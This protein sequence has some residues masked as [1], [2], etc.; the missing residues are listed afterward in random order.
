MVAKT[1][2]RFRGLWKGLLKRWLCSA[3]GLTIF[4]TSCAHFSLR[5]H[6]LAFQIEK[7]GDP[8]LRRLARSSEYAD[9]R[10]LS[11]SQSPGNELT[12]GAFCCHLAPGVLCIRTWH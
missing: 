7:S 8:P 5:E 10:T 1:V 11:D 12:I 2:K 6:H 4:D 9:C 3:R